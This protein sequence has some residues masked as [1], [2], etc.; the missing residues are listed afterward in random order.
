MLDVVRLRVLAAVARTGSVTGAARE[1]HYSQPSVSHHLARLEAE[2]GAKLVQRAGRGIRLT[3]AGRLLAERAAEIIGRVD[4][5]AAELAAHVGL[6]AGRVRLAAF[7][8]ALGTFVP[9]AAALLARGHPGLELRLT[10][11]EPPEALRMLRA[12]YVD[13]AVIFRYDD[14]APEDDGIRLVHLLDD[15]SYLVVPGDGSPVPVGSGGPKPAGP[16]PAGP[17]AGGPEP[18]GG[19]LGA[20]RDARWIA[21]CERCRSHLLDLCAKEGFKPAIAFTTDDIVAVQALVAA[22]MGVTALPGLALR[23]HRHPAVGAIELPGSTRHVYAATY[24]EPPDPP[25]TTALLKALAAVVRAAPYRPPGPD[26][27][28]DRAPD[29]APDRVSDHAPDENSAEGPDDGPD[30][31]PRSRRGAPPENRR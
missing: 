20:R 3:E 27:A 18:G 9:E 15:P 17:G 12:G 5:A 30:G 14:T 19:V 28:P 7:P 8:S 26:G 31:R 4:S 2:T 13:L 29:G 16:E 24:G 6:R 23:A 10:E 11:T 21:G 25:A 22:G 1:L